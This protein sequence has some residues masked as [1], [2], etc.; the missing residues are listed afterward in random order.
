MPPDASP[1][2]TAAATAPATGAP[3]AGAPTAAAATAGAPTAGAPTAGA[4]AAGAALTFEEAP[5]PARTA[6]IVGLGTALPE[7]RIANSEIAGPLGLADGWIERRTGISERRWVSEGE[8]VADLA[9]RAA[10]SALQDAGLDAAE[11]DLVLVATLAPDDITPGPAPLVAHAIGATH[12]AAIDVG[13]ACTG[14]IAAL[15]L[16]TA[17]I[18]SGRAS[19][20][21]IVAAEVLSR[22]TDLEDRR[23]A[24]L[25]GDGAGAI[26]LTAGATG[27][28][29]PILLDSDGGAANTIRA[30]R[31]AGV[32][33]MEGHE[34]F[35]RAVQEL[36]LSTRKVVELAGLQLNDI[37]LFVYHQAN[38]RILGA[39][40]D[41]LGLARSRVFD[42][43]ASIG[44]TSAASI[45]LALA[46]AR[47]AGALT[48]GMKIVLGAI[49]AG[50]T[51]GAAVV[52]WGE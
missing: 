20:V 21:L 23:T 31:A 44:N 8:G 51:W 32:L 46:E 9:T 36:H 41:R 33:E 6:G 10:R 43:I 38:G 19:N 28:I 4:P 12:A 7:R 30:T 13:A 26:V 18:E 22:F 14:T 35:L 50:L 37:D 48:P 42:C 11:V 40:A 52:E 15:A 49:G 25:F 3:T 2:T 34:T 1:R 39:V 47:R 29:G 24:A 27:S 45:P 5:R 16:G 17:W